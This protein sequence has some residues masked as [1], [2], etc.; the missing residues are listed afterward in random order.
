[1]VRTLTASFA[2]FVGAAVLLASSPVAACPG[3]GDDHDCPCQHKAKA[4][5][6]ADAKAEAKPDPKKAE[7]AKTESILKPVDDV[8]AA[9]CNCSGP[10][11]CTCKKGECKCKKCEKHHRIQKT[12][13]LE[14]LNG[15]P[16]TPVLPEN[17]RYDATAGVFI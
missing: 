9:T 5:A 13:L 17:A 2:A 15:T 11:D 3:M 12:Q 7:P 14:P 6:K 1:M 4:D 16:V 10:A 8:L